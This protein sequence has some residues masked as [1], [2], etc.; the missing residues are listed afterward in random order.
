MKEGIQERIKS[1]KDDNKSD[2]EMESKKDKRLP[3]G[4]FAGTAHT[5]AVRVVKTQGLETNDL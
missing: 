1:T 4:N 5:A 2:E 3:F